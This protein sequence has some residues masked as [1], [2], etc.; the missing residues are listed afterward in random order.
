MLSLLLSYVVTCDAS[1]LD[2][3]YQQWKETPEMRVE[4]AYKW[5]FHATLGGEHRVQGVDGPRNW[6]DREWASIERAQDKEPEVVRLTP[7]GSVLRVNLRP[8]KERGGDKGM[9]LWAFVFSAERFKA[10][11]SVFRRVW[12]ELGRELLTKSHGHITH[13]AW[14]RLDADTRKLGYPAI[15]HSK[16]YEEKYR[17][18]YRVVLRELWT[19]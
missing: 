15:H 17:P 1:L 9:M 19:G 10:D 11:K 4:D 2:H 7:D 8:Y 18:A 5:L 16:Q 3:A 12:N 13:Q 6:L 14:E